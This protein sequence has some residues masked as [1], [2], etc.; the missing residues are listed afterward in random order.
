MVTEDDLKCPQCQEVF[1][2]WPDHVT[3]STSHGLRDLPFG[4]T[5]APE[6]QGLS[7]EAGTPLQLASNGIRTSSSVAGNSKKPHKCELCYKSFS[8]EERLKVKYVVCFYIVQ[9]VKIQKKSNILRVCI[10]C[11]LPQFVEQ[12]SSKK[13]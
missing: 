5:E 13:H 11:N 2:S 9:W 10:S 1:I 12:K 7:V 8:T 4:T 6:G 3:H